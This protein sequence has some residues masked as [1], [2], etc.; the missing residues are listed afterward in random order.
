MRLAV[1]GASG[2]TG[3]LVVQVVGEFPQVELAAAVVS[4]TSQWLGQPVAGSSRLTYF[5]DIDRA[6]EL[7][8]VL[9]DFSRPEVSVTLAAACARR[10]KACLIATTGHTDEQRIAI[11]TA[12]EKIPLLIAANTSLGV[13]VTSRLAQ[14]AAKLLGNDVDIEIVETHHAG[15]RDAPSGTAKALAAAINEVRTLRLIRQ[16]MEPRQD[17][18]IGIVS[19]RGG[20][21]VGEHTIYFLGRGERIELTHRATDRAIFAR[22]AIYLA[23]RL[24][25]LSPG[26]KQLAD[27]L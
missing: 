1:V 3:R 27:F 15:K 24:C 16:R 11:L 2:R 22:G 25:R 6:V 14:L 20:D 18:E 23:E 17:D 12:A 19:L 7:A 9:V 5:A 26:R 4:P 13:F 21:V 8:D 10:G